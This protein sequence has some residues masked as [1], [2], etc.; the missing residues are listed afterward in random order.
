M[1]TDPALLLVINDN[2]STRPYVKVPYVTGNADRLLDARSL[3]TEGEAFLDKPFTA[4]GLCEAVSLLLTGGIGR[5][6][7]PAKRRAW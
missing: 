1:T 4:N 6:P 2:A 7:A 3:L 5:E